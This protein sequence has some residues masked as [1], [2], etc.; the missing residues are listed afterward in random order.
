MGRPRKKIRYRVVGECYECVSHS[1]GE[2]GYPTITRNGKFQHIIR[3]LY[4]RRHGKL[5]PGQVARH[6][7]DNRLCIRVEHAIPGTIQDNIK[8][9]DLRGRTARGTKN[10]SAKITE[11]DV[12]Y[13]RKSK[14]PRAVLAEK[15]DLHPVYVSAI[16]GRRVW[17]HVI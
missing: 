4:E 15:F 6:T 8:D 1:P 9:R 17:K 13:I 14:K 16:R 5:P 2:R 10:G 3:Y 11:D 7:C 12:R